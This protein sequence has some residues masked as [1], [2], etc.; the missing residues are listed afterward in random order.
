MEIRESG[1]CIDTCEWIDSSL[2]IVM[3]MV[4]GCGSCNKGYSGVEAYRCLDF[5]A[6]KVYGRDHKT[7]AQAT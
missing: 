4:G 7:G 3:M 2:A 6:V 5:T 1:C